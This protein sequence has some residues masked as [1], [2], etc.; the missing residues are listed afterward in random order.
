MADIIS[1][2]FW[3]SDLGKSKHSLRNCLDLFWNSR[4]DTFEGFGI[5]FSGET[6]EKQET[7]ASSCALFVIMLLSMR[8]NGAER[9]IW[10]SCCADDDDVICWYVIHGSV[11]HVSLNNIYSVLYVHVETDGV[12]SGCCQECC[13]SVFWKCFEGR[14][15]RALFN[16]H[17]PDTRPSARPDMI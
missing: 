15:S 7:S 3:A 12:G 4:R 1:T 10:I 13:V 17:R 14:V 16:A 9:A 8:N 2:D 6:P 5:F 11:I